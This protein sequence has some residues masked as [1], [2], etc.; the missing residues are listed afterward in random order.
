MLRSLTAPLLVV[1]LLAG[2]DADGTSKAARP[3]DGIVYGVNRDGF[4]EIWTMNSHGDGAKRL[5]PQVKPD[6]DASGSTSP[7][8]SPDGT[9]IA[10]ASRGD[11]VAEDQRDI[12]IYVMDSDGSAVRRLTDDDV[13]DATPAWSP[14]GEHIAF[15]HTPGSGREK[16]AGVIGRI[17]ADGGGRTQLPRHATSEAMVIDSQPA[18]SPD[19]R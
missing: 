6:T 13:L 10:Y 14:E 5:T 4:S 9:Q 12:D 16:G 11:A 17:D 8:W 1:V 2:C 3:A 15:A 18:W 7:A 19:G